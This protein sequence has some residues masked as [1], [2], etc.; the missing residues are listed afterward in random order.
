MQA[1]PHICN[2]QFAPDQA[3]QAAPM[4]D[5]C[6]HSTQEWF[7][8]PLTLY[9]QVHQLG[10]D[11]TQKDWAILTVK[12]LVLGGIVHLGGPPHASQVLVIYWRLYMGAV[13]VAVE[14][15]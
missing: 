13:M 12:V 15:S 2:D 7:V 8:Q 6:R 5:S 1:P 10:V 14:Q 11:G 4:L 9:W 3:A